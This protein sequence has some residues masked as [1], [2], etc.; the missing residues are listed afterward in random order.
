[1]LK[2]I[3]THQDRVIYLGRNSKKCQY[4]RSLCPEFEQARQC[5]VISLYY[6]ELI[7]NYLHLESEFCL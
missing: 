6:C 3:A 7:L 4:F 5:Y 1:M 2:E